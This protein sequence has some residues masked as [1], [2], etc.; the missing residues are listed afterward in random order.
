MNEKHQGIH[1]ADNELDPWIE[2]VLFSSL[3]D[4]KDDN[5]TISLFFRNKT[6]LLKLI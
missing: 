1:F 3:N 5:Q 2:H 6:K 4:S